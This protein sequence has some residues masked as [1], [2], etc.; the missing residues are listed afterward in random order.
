MT[1][2]KSIPKISKGPPNP[3]FSSVR[4]KKVR[5][6]RKELTRFKKYFSTWAPMKCGDLILA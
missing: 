5:F 3:G 2:T 1:F 4:V 6:S